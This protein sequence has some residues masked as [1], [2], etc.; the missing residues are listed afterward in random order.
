[1]LRRLRGQTLLDLRRA[2]EAL[3]LLVDA[4]RRLE[5][6]DP[7]LARDTHLEAVRAASVAGRLGPG[8]LEAANAARTAPPRP[9]GPRAV[10]LL[11]DGLAVRFTDGYA[12]SA[13]AL[14][15][16][17]GR[18]SRRG[19]SRGTKR[20]LAVAGPARSAGPVRRRHLALPRH[21]RRRAGA[22]ERRA[23]AC[24]HSR[25]T[26]SRTCAAWR[27]SWT[28][29]LRYSTR[30][31]RSRPRPASSRW[32]SGDLTLAGFRGH[33]GGG[34]GLVRRD[35]A[36][37]DR[38]GR[39]GRAHVLRARARGSLQRSRPLRGRPRTRPKRERTR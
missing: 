32:C 37:C 33:R 29:P 36:D 14:K 21:P 7:G 23:R 17:A 27:A 6:I 13:P 24:S 20:P 35:R 12:A 19:R 8:M 10:D 2:A 30:R 31:T 34:S 25:S 3:P 28:A 15:A 26:I 39:G 18:A 5:P 22:R 1:M 9:G 16:R 11:L 38:A 4:A